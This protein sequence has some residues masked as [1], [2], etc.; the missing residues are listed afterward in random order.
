M[1]VYVN[2]IRIILLVAGLTVQSVSAQK[3]AYSATQLGKLKYANNVLKEGIQKNDSLQIAEAYYLLGKIEANTGN[4]LVSQKLFLKSLH[5]QELYGNSYNLGRLYMRLHENEINQGHYEEGFKYLKIALSIFQRIKSDLG[6]SHAYTGL[7]RFY[8]PTSLSEDSLKRPHFIKH[9]YDSAF[10]YYKKAEIHTRQINDTLS[11]AYLQIA[12]G[13][14]S[15]SQKNPNVIAYYQ[16]ALNIFLSKNKKSETLHTMLDLAGAYISINQPQKAYPLI[17]Q[18]Q[19]LYNEELLNEYD[20]QH[21]LEN[22]YVTYFQAVGNWKQAFKHLENANKLGKRKLLA[23]HEGAVSRLNVE[24]ETEKKEELLKI[25]KKEIA[26]QTEN[27]KIQRRFLITFAL[28]ALL[29][30]IL[31]FV[32]YRLYRKNQRISQ[33]NVVLVKEQNHRVKNNL[34]VVSSLLSLQS[35]RLIDGSAKKAVEESML[36]VE[37]MA[38][39]H[40]K[41]YDGE[42]LAIINLPD[43]IIELVE[44]VLKTFGFGY[45]EPTYKMDKLKLS[46][47]QAL[48]VGLI[49]NELVTNSCKYAF[50]ENPNPSIT[51]ACFS[52]KNELVITVADNGPGF[53]NPLAPNYFIETPKTFGIRLI[54]MQI[55]QLYGS[56]T[57]E[58]EMGVKFTMR[59]KPINNLAQNIL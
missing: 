51:I 45:I 37:A 33:R 29:T 5:I 44:T 14:L 11:L 30:V 56:Y 39:L 26:L 57:F 46:A 49:I 16:T 13:G 43:F 31:S 41:L 54:Q 17:L 3:Y 8:A 42:D 40:R 21:H 50:P 58:S 35:N 1:P 28:L 32:F 52:E 10:Y 18:A 6:L 22:L 47:D 55:A 15:Q 20:S 36:R 12:F 9:N 48:P 53:R 59:F 7:G 27:L 24:Y 19:K 38:I 4:Y 2:F 25:Q 23:D 34:Q